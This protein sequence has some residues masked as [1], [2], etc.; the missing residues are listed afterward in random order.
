MGNVR[1]ANIAQ[2]NEGSTVSSISRKTAAL[3]AGAALAVGGCT[4]GIVIATQGSG[5]AAAGHDG[6]ATARAAAAQSA[7]LRLVSVSPAAG[8]RDVNGAGAITVTYNQPLSATAPLPTLSPAIAGSWRRK[9]DA[10]IFRPATGYPAGTRV[11]VRVAG[12]GG[13]RIRSGTSSFE[14]G[15]YSTVRLQEI[16]AQLRYLPLTWTPAR[17]A[18]A[19]GGSAAAQLSAAYAPP[20]GTFHWQRG[21]PEQ[22]GSFWAQGKANTLDRG[23]I[24]GFEADHGLPINGVAGSSV[25]R[26]LLTA[27]ARDQRNTHG[28]S[29]AIA[30][31]HEPET[32]TIWHD[33]KKVFSSF[34][35]T[36][37]GVAPTGVGTFP[38]Y[39]KLPF[40]IMQGTNPDGSHYS[41]PVEWVSYFDGGDAVHYFD[42]GSYGWPQSLG[43]VELPYDAAE[44]AYPYLPYGTLV[45]VTP[46]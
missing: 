35:N 36:G 40:Q 26:A 18:T 8:R 44:R 28:Y 17:G 23:A 25:W 29:Y 39:E 2:R 22:L 41:D 9:G 38:V 3:A 42:R 19:P 4:A 34:A 24:I 5:Q 20:A 21:Y 7:P 37:I 46:E 16:L 6:T 32:L 1:H 30:S 15:Q 10:V 45:T 14:T 11:T 27:A 33:G 31:Q 12:T 43:C 13:S